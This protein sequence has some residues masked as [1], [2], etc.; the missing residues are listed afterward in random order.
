LMLAEF[1]YDLKPC[2]TFPFDQGKE[3]R[4]MYLLKKHLLP[5][6]Y[7]QGLIRG[8][9]WPWPIPEGAPPHA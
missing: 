1:D 5:A 4:S 8:R 6:L 2:E 3:R 7:W 9:K